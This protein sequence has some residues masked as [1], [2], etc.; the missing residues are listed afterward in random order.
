MNHP[1]PTTHGA[2]RVINGQLVD[3]STRAPLI[4]STDVREGGPGIPVP[5]A[6]A[7]NP[8][9]ATGRKKSQSKE[10]PNGTA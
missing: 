4:A 10:S 3:E 7:P 1:T 5:A 9:V 2:W 8:P 6:D